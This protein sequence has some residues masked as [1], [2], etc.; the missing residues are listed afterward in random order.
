MGIKMK[1]D[2]WREP[3]IQIGAWAV[4][5]GPEGAD[6]DCATEVE[7]ST[8]RQYQHVDGLI[9]DY[10]PSTPFLVTETTVDTKRDIGIRKIVAIGVEQLSYWGGEEYWADELPK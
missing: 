1:I 7:G 3:D 2:A 9:E 8:V 6:G 10:E 4:W 5:Y